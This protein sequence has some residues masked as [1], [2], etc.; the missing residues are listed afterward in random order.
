MSADRASPASLL[1]RLRELCQSPEAGP[2]GGQPGQGATPCRGHPLALFTRP[3]RVRDLRCAVCE[4][5]CAEPVQLACAGEHLVCER[6]LAE[7]GAVVDC[8]VDG[9]RGVHARIVRD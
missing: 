1:A 5:V 6:A 2:G 9:E 8:P 7:H 3:A 4:H